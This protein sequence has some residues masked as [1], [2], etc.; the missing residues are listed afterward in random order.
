VDAEIRPA[1]LADL[2]RSPPFP[3]V[4]HLEAHFEGIRAEADRLADS[5]YEDW[6]L[7]DAYQGEWKICCLYSRDPSWL[8]ARRCAHNAQRCPRTRRCLERIP[9]LLLG[10]FSRLGP[11]AHIY[12]HVDH[13]PVAS[14]RCHLGL[15]VH[16]RARMRFGDEIVRWEAGRCLLFDGRRQHE[17][18][19]L[20]VTPRVV[21]LV[22]VARDCLERE[23]LP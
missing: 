5:D 15:R 16:D 3:F 10:G 13:V 9:G 22:D 20:G 18:A 8:Y 7:E 2:L 23:L 11:G 4:E 12:P 21:C 14:R 17:V 19:N 1:P 6:P